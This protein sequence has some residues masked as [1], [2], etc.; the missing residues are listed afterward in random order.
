MLSPVPTKEVQNFV[1]S[2]QNELLETSIDYYRE[3]G[4]RLR[5][6]RARPANSNMAVSINSPAQGEKNGTGSPHVTLNNAALNVRYEFKAATFAEFRAEIEVALK[7]YEDCYS[8]LLDLFTNPVSATNTHPFILARTKRWAEARVLADC[9]IVK[10]SKMYLYSGNAEYAVLTHHHHVRRMSHIS[11]SKWGMDQTSFEYWSWESKQHR[12][13]GDLIEAAMGA[14]FKIPLVPGPMPGPPL[15][16]KASAQHV[17]AQVLQHPGAYYLRAGLAAEVRRKLFLV[18]LQ[19]YEAAYSQ[20]MTD[21]NIDEPPKMSAA[22]AHEK[23]APH[24]DQIIELYTKAYDHYKGSRGVRMT[25]S[26]AYSIARVHHNNGALDTALRFDERI[27]K[28]YRRE[29]WLS[30][31]DSILAR[32]ASALSSQPQDATTSRPTGIDDGGSRE[33]QAELR[34]DHA[35]LLRDSFKICMERLVI[36]SQQ[37]KG[38]KRADVTATSVLQSLVSRATNPLDSISTSPVELSSVDLPLPLAFKASF[39]RPCA[40]L[41]EAIPYQICFQSSLL[42]DSAVDFVNITSMEIHYSDERPPVVVSHDEQAPTHGVVNLVDGVATTAQLKWLLAEG[43]VMG[44]LSSAFVQ[45]VS[46]SQCPLGL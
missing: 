44:T 22:L 11:A 8:T 9:L 29:R 41:G 23:S 10:I 46:V 43:V 3:H 28:T 12:I 13:F 6:K 26:L 30:V 4:R 20:A 27:S 2:L 19:H 45:T 25:L 21:P 16:A 34:S 7:H 42:L 38:I 31:L 5:R 40:T 33:Q 36:L 17:P 39:W 15:Q 35:S 1:S 24:A 32:D 18:A 14:G 37:D